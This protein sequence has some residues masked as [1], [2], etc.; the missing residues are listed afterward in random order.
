M[1]SLGEGISS[2]FACGDVVF[3]KKLGQEG[4]IGMIYEIYSI[5]MGGRSIKK[6]KICSLKDT[7]DYDILLLEL[8]LVSKAG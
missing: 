4:N 5:E 3:W 2:E 6:A 7:L 1:S 8:K